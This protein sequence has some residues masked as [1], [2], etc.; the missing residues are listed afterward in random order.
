M[1]I[2]GVVYVLYMK[3]IAYLI[4]MSVAGV[5]MIREYSILSKELQLSVFYL[6]FLSHHVL[7][8]VNVDN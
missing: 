2:L 6:I 8:L 5:G 4:N 3:T 7:P 1:S